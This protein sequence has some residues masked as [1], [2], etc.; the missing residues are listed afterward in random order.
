MLYRYAG[1]PEGDGDLQDF[2]DAE[3]IDG[4][5]VDAFKWVVTNGIVNGMDDGTLNPKGNASRA[6]VAQILMRF[7]ENK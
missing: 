6:Q 5:A 7:L 2:A 4:F 1:N 3:Q